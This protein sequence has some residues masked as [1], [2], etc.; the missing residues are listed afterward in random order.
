MLKQQHDAFRRLLDLCWAIRRAYTE[1]D[2][3]AGHREFF[4]AI[5]AATRALGQEPVDSARADEGC[6]G[7][8]ALITTRQPNNG[9]I[10]EGQF[11]G[12]GD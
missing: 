5:D 2:I 3:G 10:G 12:R 6:I 8:K 1:N 11:I 9:F 4:E 7:Y